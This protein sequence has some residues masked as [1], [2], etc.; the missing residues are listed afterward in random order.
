MLPVPPGV[1]PQDYERLGPV[2]VGKAMHAISAQ[3]DPTI[4]WQ[5][6][7]NSQGGISLPAGSR[8]AREQQRRLQREG[9]QFAPNGRVPFTR[10][11]GMGQMRHGCVPMGCAR[12]W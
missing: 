11:A 3:D 7:I 6:V 12:R 5:R 10:M 2:W 4:P 1:S 8:L 9:V